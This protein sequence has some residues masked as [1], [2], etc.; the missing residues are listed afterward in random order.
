MEEEKVVGIEKGKFVVAMTA[1]IKKCLHA[2]IVPGEAIRHWGKGPPPPPPPPPLHGP[3]CWYWPWLFA[4]WSQFGF[5]SFVYI[6]LFKLLLCFLR[7]AIPKK[8]QKIRPLLTPP[9]ELGTLHLLRSSIEL[10][11]IACSNF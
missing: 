7:E 5:F 9:A 6:K 8:V 4:L 10:K 1:D 3:I 2:T 11:I